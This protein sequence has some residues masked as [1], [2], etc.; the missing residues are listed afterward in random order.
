MINL[1]LISPR[2][3]GIYPKWIVSRAGPV[4]F[5]VN[6]EIPPGVSSGGGARVVT[7]SHIS[8]CVISVPLYWR[9]YEI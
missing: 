3:L 9:A 1:K 8:L 2:V 6:Q 4:G 5:A 7:G